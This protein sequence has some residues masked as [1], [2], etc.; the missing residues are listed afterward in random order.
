MTTKNKHGFEF[1]IQ[2]ETR[3]VASFHMRMPVAGR[4]GVGAK[5]HA[6]EGLARFDVTRGVDREAIGLGPD[7]AAS[8]LAPLTQSAPDF[9]TFDDVK[10]KDSDYI[11]PLFR[12]LSKAVIEGHWLDFTGGNVLKDSMPL[13]EA[14]T[15]YKNHYFYDVE[16]WVGVVNQVA[17]DEQGEQTD[18]VPG[19]NAELKIDWK[20][21]PLI[22]RGLLMEPPAIHSVSV[23]VL[24]EFE[25]SHP[26]L[27]EESKWTF[28]DMLG[29]E[30]GGEIVRFI[31][32]KILAYWEI[33]LVFQGADTRANVD[34]VLD[35]AREQ[36]S[37]DSAR[38]TQQ[39]VAPPVAQP[40]NS[41]RSS[42][43]VK[44]TAERKK[45]LG[46]EAHQ[47]EEVD[48]EIVLRVVDD[49]VT[50]A[51]AGTTLLDAERQEVLSLAA[52]AEGVAEGETL[53]EAIAESINGAS[54]TT[55][56]K[57]KAH[58]EKKAAEKFTSRCNKCG[59]T[60]VANR[61]SV[62]AVPHEVGAQKKPARRVKLH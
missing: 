54:A 53:P 28:Y 38:R 12:A 14:Q 60:D 43:K 42:K 52:V 6:A 47:G 5:P 3:K 34:D 57:Q 44:L 18:G 39:A 49:L 13:L 16:R 62:E 7:P 31:V 17:W 36:L 35:A 29:E 59:S 45:K 24:A 21:N 56:A 8:S 32:T 23:T 46:L 19:I 25:P 55:L 10:P 27:W 51:E 20:V 1:T 22:A 4:F 2:N 61:S 41:E 40:T 30:L 58:Y 15:V 37:A 26:A 9:T 11:F 50:R 33:S 48:D